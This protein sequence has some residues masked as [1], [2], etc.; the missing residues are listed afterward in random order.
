MHALRP[1]GVRIPRAFKDP[2]TKV[3]I[4]Y[5]GYVVALLERLG[6]LPRSADP[7]LR[8]YGLLACE[9]EELAGNIEAARKRRRVT[10]ATR[11]GRRLVGLTEALAREEER[12]QA[13]ATSR[14]LT[15]AERL[16]ALPNVGEG[17]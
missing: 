12:L 11:L 14:P 4:K 2:R 15:T 6:P 10:V 5:R 9:I 1:G 3:A 16:A 13:L 7:H 17:S 8:A